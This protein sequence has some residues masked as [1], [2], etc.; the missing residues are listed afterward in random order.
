MGDIV[1]SKV[2]AVAAVPPPSAVAED[3]KELQTVLKAPARGKLAL[4]PKRMPRSGLRKKEKD[5]EQKEAEEEEEK[6][7]GAQ[8]N[9]G[10]G[11]GGGGGGG[12]KGQGPHVGK[13]RPWHSRFRLSEIRRGGGDPED[14]SCGQGEG[15]EDTG[16]GGGAAAAAEGVRFGEVTMREAVVLRAADRDSSNARSR[17]GKGKEFVGGRKSLGPNFVLAQFVISAAVRDEDFFHLMERTPATMVLVICDAD[18][19]MAEAD[20]LWSCL[21]VREYMLQLLEELG[22]L[23]GA[24]IVGLSALFYKVGH[25]RVTA[26][27]VCDH[28][29]LEDDDTSWMFSSFNVTLAGDVY[30]PSAVVA[31]ACVSR[32]E[33]G[34]A[35]PWGTAFFWQMKERIVGDKVRFLGGLMRGAPKEQVEDLG[36][37]CGATSTHPVHQAWRRCVSSPYSDRLFLWVTHAAYIIPFGQCTKIALPEPE[38][39]Y[40]TVPIWLQGSTCEID[41][42]QIPCF[43]D[44]PYDEPRLGVWG[45][46]HL[47]DLRVLKQKPADFMHWVN[48]VHQ[49][50]LWVGINRKGRRGADLTEEAAVADTR[51]KQR[52]RSRDI[53]SSGSARYASRSSGSGAVFWSG[54]ATSF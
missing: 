28:G 34:E 24:E 26:V 8:G 38:A 9:G 31:V 40:R 51:K 33:N 42:Q 7:E 35:E 16:G 4:T 46:P 15:E 14:R 47:S 43:G 17:K 6:E 45:D 39:E 20:S 30:T 41:R 18:N 25:G 11:R 23:W 52:H 13:A 22:G 10:K 19:S 49:L 21:T 5:E 48:G 32:K 29:P 44:N 3:E 36:R 2:A 12:G 27:A 53:C 37:S 50:I 1:A 54:A